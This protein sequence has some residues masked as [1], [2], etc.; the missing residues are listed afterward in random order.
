MN[1]QYDRG[2]ATIICT[3]NLKVVKMASKNIYFKDDAYFTRIKE[4]LDPPNQS[5]RGM[6]TIIIKVPPKKNSRFEELN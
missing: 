5:I 1:Y 3:N 4:Y 6:R 2:L